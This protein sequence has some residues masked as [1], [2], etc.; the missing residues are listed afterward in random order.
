VINDVLASR[1]FKERRPI[2]QIATVANRPA[3]IVGVM[4]S[5]F[6]RALDRPPGPAVYHLMPPASGALVTYV[7]RAAAD[8][9][10]PAGRIQRTLWSITPDVI[11]VQVATLGELLRAGVLDRTFAAAI[12]VSFALVGLLV[13]LAGVAGLVSAIVI[14]RR[15][16]M[17]IR[18]A[19]GAPLGRIRRMVMSRVVL[20]ALAGI[21]LGTL[22]GRI[23]SQM[24]DSL[25]YGVSP[26]SWPPILIAAA[27][28]LL[29]TAAAAVVPTRRISMQTATRLVRTQ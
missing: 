8:G 11:V 12:S 3:R 2:G 26:A 20:A 10:V 1:H 15:D 7:V 27:I 22:A 17:A 13:S 21:A 16:E 9:E 18:L 4:A 6:D 23:F 19:L 5:V 29:L 28:V 25:V 14:E 24:L